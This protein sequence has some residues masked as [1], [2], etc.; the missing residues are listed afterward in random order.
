MEDPSRTLEGNFRKRSESVSRAFPDILEFLPESP[1]RTGGMAQFGPGTTTISII[2]TV[3]RPN[4]WN[5]TSQPPQA[6]FERTEPMEPSS[7]PRKKMERTEPSPEPRLHNFNCRGINL[8]TACVSLVSACLAPMTSQQGN[9]TTIML[10]D[11]ISNC[12]HTSCTSL[13]VGELIV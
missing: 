11:L 1:S 10:G 12:T 8:C 7:P 2:H 13:I 4:L 3:P 6:K 5:L 9:Y